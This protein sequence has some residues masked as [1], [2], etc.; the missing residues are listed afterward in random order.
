MK[1]I[2]IFM[3][4][5]SIITIHAAEESSVSDSYGLL[6]GSSYK[7]SPNYSITA[8]LGQYSD[9]DSTN[10]SLFPN[11]VNNF[12]ASDA[13]VG[14]A[15]KY[16]EIRLGVHEPL[17]GFS[18]GSA[19]QQRNEGAYDLLL[20]GEDKPTQSLTYLGKVGG[21]SAGAQISN[22]DS[23]AKKS[24]TGLLLNAESRSVEAAIGYRQTDDEAK[25]LKGRLTYKSRNNSRMRV[26]LIAEKV[27]IDTDG[28]G[29]SVDSTLFMLGAKYSMT[30][31]AYVAGQ[32]GVVGFDGGAEFSTEDLSE[33]KDYNALS[34]E[35]GYSLSGKTSV[36]INHTQKSFDSS[37]QLPFEDTLEGSQTNSI[38]VRL[39]W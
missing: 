5:C 28:S 7:L 9:L 1:K 39:N 36:Y 13:W 24:S 29:K 37:L 4:L 14:V 27:A 12:D 15:G 3:S 33:S 31:R 22:D 30:P 8:G 17:D 23:E 6:S 2:I 11:S 21:I 10:Y 19:D 20:Q 25:A 38:G 26:D 32:Y 34:L 16:G 18:I 35:A